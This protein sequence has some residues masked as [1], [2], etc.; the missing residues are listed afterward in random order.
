MDY[1]VT[2]PSVFYT[3]PTVLLFNTLSFK[4]MW[5]SNEQFQEGNLLYFK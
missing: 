3:K 2:R 1:Y 5:V 4:L